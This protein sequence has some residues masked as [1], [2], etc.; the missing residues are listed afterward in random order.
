M[1]DSIT[2]LARSQLQSQL[3]RSSGSK[4]VKETW[5]GWLGGIARGVFKHLEKVNEI[6]RRTGDRP[7]SWHCQRSSSS[8][9]PTSWGLQP[10]P[11]KKLTELDLTG[12]GGERDIDSRRQGCRAHLLVVHAHERGVLLDGGGPLRD[13]RVP[14]RVGDLVG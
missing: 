4:L 14:R 7:Q 2:P 9:L 8:S 3:V 1:K 10:V 11:P 12:Q 5:R 13:E 6:G